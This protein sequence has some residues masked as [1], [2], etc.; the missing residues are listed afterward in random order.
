MYRSFFKRF[1][2]FLLSGIALLILSPIYAVLAYKVKKD[3]GSPIIFH[4]ERATKGGK[5]FNL[6]KFRSMTNEKDADGNLLPDS[7]RRTKFGTFLRNSSLDELPEIW[8]IFKGDMSIIGP[9]PLRTVDNVYFTEKEKDRFL[10]RG[11]LIPPEVLKNNPTPTWDE[12][13][14][15]EAEYGRN[16]SFVTDVVILFKVFQLLF[17]RSKSDYGEYERKPLAT[18]RKEYKLE[19]QA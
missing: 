15:W 1:I 9:R 17:N 4:Q 2:D 19:P 16:C 14:E 8:N 18:E 10:V 11:G 7:M 3:M 12:Q 6:C 13:L 5:S